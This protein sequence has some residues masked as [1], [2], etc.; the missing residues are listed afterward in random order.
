MYL[1]THL[2]FKT[3]HKTL[4]FQEKL[5][6]VRKKEWIKVR[7]SVENAFSSD[8]NLKTFP[9]GAPYRDSQLRKQ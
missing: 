1:S 8:L 7:K 9:F 4:K 2:F 3:P 5:E 6:R